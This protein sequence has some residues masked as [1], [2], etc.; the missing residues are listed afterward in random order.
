MIDFSEDALFS[1]YQE[2]VAQRDKKLKEVQHLK[3]A[4]EKA[5][6]AANKAR[7]EAARRAAVL[8]EA[9]GG[10]DWLALKK[11]IAVL[12]RA[13]SKENGVLATK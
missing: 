6:E 5:N 9:M 11:N 4:V 13:L 7:E 2:L 3:D 8:S 10:A 1:K 12:A